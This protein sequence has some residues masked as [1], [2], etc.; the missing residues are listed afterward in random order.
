[1]NSDRRTEE[2]KSPVPASTSTSDS[3]GNHVDVMD[4]DNASFTETCDK[5]VEETLA[6]RPITLEYTE[7]QLAKLAEQLEKKEKYSSYLQALSDEK[8]SRVH[9]DA[10]ANLRWECLEPLMREFVRR[11]NEKA[12]DKSSFFRKG[13]I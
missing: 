6:N 13:F 9:K 12:T 8:L 10:M 2:S 5:E 1:M 7:E 11:S 3:E 4:E